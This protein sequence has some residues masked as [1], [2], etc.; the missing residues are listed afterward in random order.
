VQAQ[1]V[2]E[3]GSWVID[4]DRRELRMRG[5]SVPIGSRA[6][7]IIETLAASAGQLVTKDDLM[8]QVWPGVLV[9]ENTLQVHISAIRKALGPDRAML[10]TAAGRGYRLVGSWV[11]RDDGAEAPYQ[12]VQQPQG[13]RG[14]LTNIPSV[15]TTLIGRSATVPL[16]RDLVSA[17]RV[18]TLTGPGGI[19]KTTLAVEVARSLLDEFEDGRWLVELAS[20]SDPEL[21][22]STT[23]GALALKFGGEA[24]SA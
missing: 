21:V 5:A 9:E 6:F 19:G 24:I 20:L 7:G 14:P 18:V 16:L 1:F 11:V 8:A 12:G 4:A 22:P 3:A 10:K 13:T 15:V 23:A 2:L 17:Y